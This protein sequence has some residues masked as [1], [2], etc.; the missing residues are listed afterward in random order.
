M[1]KSEN[2]HMG[3]GKVVSWIAG[4]VGSVIAGVVVV[5]ITTGNHSSK[6]PG[7][8]VDTTSSTA[9]VW[10]QGNLTIPVSSVNT[11]RVADLDSGRLLPLGTSIPVRDADIIVRQAVHGIVVEPGISKGDGVTFDARFIAVNDASVG[12]EGCADAEASPRA[13]NHLQLFSAINVGSHIC[14]VTTKGRL[15]EFTVT[16]VEL[17]RKPRQVRIKF[18]VWTRE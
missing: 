6:G 3:V 13:S 16:S 5:L 12:R 17:S 1:S 2:Q 15:A 10:K 14:M 4:I 18:V 11:G 8:I 9:K 7:P